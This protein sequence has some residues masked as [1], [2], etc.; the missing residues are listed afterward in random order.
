MSNMPKEDI[1]DVVSLTTEADCNAL[2]GFIEEAVLCKQ[3]VESE[4][5]ALKDIRNEAKERLKVKPA[6]FNKMVTA[7]MKDSLKKARDDFEEFDEIM[8]K[9]YPDLGKQ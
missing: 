6:M 2:R 8:G 3:R 4:N 9:L 7:V 5:E 1:Y